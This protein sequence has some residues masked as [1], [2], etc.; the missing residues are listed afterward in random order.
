MAILISEQ[1]EYGK[2][3]WKWEHTTADRHPSDPS[4]RGMRP[5]SFQPYPAM[6]YKATQN[7]PWKFEEHIVGDA[8]EQRNLES[9][10]FVAG[11]Q[12]AAAAAYEAAQQAVAVAAAERN[13]QDRNMGEK[14]RAESDA[15]EQ[16]S[17]KHLGEIPR[18]PITRRG[19]P[20][21]VETVS[22]E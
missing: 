17:S 10:G 5:V 3:A 8:H 22:T 2:E 13:W 12:A 4:I 16:A 6:L 14:A 18:T 15:V 21:K 1:S 11:G 20:R 19:R 7:N 9:R